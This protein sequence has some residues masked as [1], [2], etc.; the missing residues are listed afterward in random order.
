MG[1]LHLREP[2]YP[3]FEVYKGTF[4]K[5]PHS[6]CGNQIVHTRRRRAMTRD[7]TAATKALAL[8]WATAALIGLVSGSC[9][10]KGEVS[11]PVT[12]SAPA[13][14]AEPVGH[15]TGTI[16]AGFRPGTMPPGNT[17]P[18]LPCAAPTCRMDIEV[19]NSEDTRIGVVPAGEYSIDLAPGVY[20]LAIGGSPFP[21]RSESCSVKSAKPRTS[22]RLSS[23]FTPNG[24][25][26][27]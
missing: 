25:V 1:R 24:Q 2:A 8:T 16:T 9:S 21:I 5:R 10:A 13:K 22:I 18:F 4:A 14:A 7:R 19:R 15:V 6:A 27:E 23:S 3:I 26:A 17:D 11:A 12:I 20:T